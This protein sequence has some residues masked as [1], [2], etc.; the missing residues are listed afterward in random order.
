MT[1]RNDPDQHLRSGLRL[2]GYDYSGAGAYFVTICTHNRV[3]AFG[4]VD[5]AAM[6]LNETGR[7]VASCWNEIP[8]HF[9]TIILDEWVIMPN[10]IHG[11]VIITDE[12]SAEAT[13]ASPIRPALGVVVGPFKSAATKRVNEWRRARGSPLWQRNYYEHVIRDEADLT[14]IRQYIADN[15]IRWADDPENPNGTSGPL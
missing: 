10:H 4:A 13:R 7:I 2:Q 15:P 11:I 5:D 9:S 8:Q 12:S 6:Q 1:I 14:R 3:C